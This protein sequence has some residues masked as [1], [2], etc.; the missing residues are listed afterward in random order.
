MKRLLPLAL[1]IGAAGLNAQ[2]P[3]DASLGAG[4]QFVQYEIKA[5]INEKISEIAMPIFVSIPINPSLTFDVGS[6]W[7]WSRVESSGSGTSSTST[8]NGPTDTQIRASYTFGTDFVVLTAG[9]NVPTGTSTAGPNEQLAATRIGNDFLAF[10]ITNLGTGFG[11]TGGIAIAR[12]LG[13][14]NF[15]IGASM[16]H[17]A[18]YDPFEDGAGTR[19]R[20]EP[21]DEYRARIGV[22]RA[23]GT[24]RMTLGVTYSA[25]GSDMVA[26]SAYNTGNRIVAQGSVNNMMGPADVTVAAWNLY[27]ASGTLADNSSI[28][29]DNLANMYVGLGFH[30][31]SAILQPGVEVRNWQ[32][33]GTRPSTLVNLGLR[34]QL[35]LGLLTLSPGVTYSMGRFASRGSAAPLADVSGVHAVVSGRIAR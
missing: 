1:V 17:S 3:Q 8:I 22:D 25:F 13:Q 12:P 2:S 20:Y 7:V 23:I 9:V 16:R 32:Q 6:A 27:R 35:S 15:G 24:G 28:G 31:G 10:P 19:L 4:P 5:P 29:Y 33:E 14:W 30:A 26:G 18:A 11:G 21:G 34:S